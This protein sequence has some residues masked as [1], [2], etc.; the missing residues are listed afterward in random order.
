MSIKLMCCKCTVTYELALSKCPTC[1]YN[2]DHHDFGV[3]PCY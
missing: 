2:V 3:V 1:P